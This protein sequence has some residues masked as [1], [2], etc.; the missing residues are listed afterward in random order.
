MSHIGIVRGE[1]NIN[2][3]EFSINPEEIVEFGEYVVTRNKKGE[4]VI[5]TVRDIMERNF[6]LQSSRD[7]YL[8]LEMDI[9]QYGESLK[10]CEE[11]I[12]TVKVL[13][14]LRENGEKIDILPNRVPIPPGE[15]VYFLDSEILKKLYN[16][17]GCIDIGTLINREEVPVGL[18]VN[19]LISRHFSVL[20]VTGA[21]KSNAISVIVSKLVENYNGTVVIL[22]PHGDYIK[23]KLPKTGYEKVNII[24]AKINPNDMDYEELA[25]LIG[26]KKEASIQRGFLA[27]ALETVKY[28]RSVGGRELIE[29][30]MEKLE[31]WVNIRTINYYDPNKKIM[32]DEEISANDAETIRRA[33]MRIKR[34]LRNYGSLLSGEDL[35]GKI[36]E[37]KV[38][39]IDLGALNEEQMRIVGG[40]LL[41]EIFEERVSYEKIL[42]NLERFK[43]TKVPIREEME[44]ELERIRERSKALTKPILIIVEEAHIFAP[45]DE[46]ND[47]SLILSKI[48]REGRKFGVGLGIVSQ[49]PNKLNEDILSQTNTKII[50][51]I[52]NPRDQRYVLEA[53]EQL[54]E[55]LLRDIPSLG[56]G[57]A[58]IVGQAISLPALV[59][60][61]NFKELG[62]DYGGGD[63]D[64]IER[65]GEEEE[66]GVEIDEL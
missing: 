12:A 49:R 17:E 28:E 50:L 15:R 35:I 34:F 8:S 4:M 9:K 62:G 44:K 61:Y 5:G 41:K 51:R 57:E 26:I 65:W 33:V 27:K 11:L 19:D 29:K 32:K 25:D 43:F 42:K 46:E 18:K 54:S 66:E 63:I 16:A 2:Y 10:E 52:V 38:N 56:K 48:A 47:A 37:G 13:G 14:K 6:L 30:V 60:I 22:D 24:E 31:D 55:D 1:S 45:R 40:R 64:I 20:A 59:K 58:V 23:L 21:G 39:V 7:N 53:S 36:E 3:F